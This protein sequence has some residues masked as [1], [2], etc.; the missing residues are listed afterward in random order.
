MSEKIVPT[1]VANFK[2]LQEGSM[3]LG[4]GVGERRLGLAPDVQIL[5]R[6][7]WRR[8]AVG[9]QRLGS[10]VAQPG[11]TCGYVVQKVEHDLL[12]IAHQGPELDLATVA[13]RQQ[14]FQ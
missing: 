2:L 14:N 9:P 3:A 7:W 4:Q 6:C 11:G 12:V 8:Y 10:T 1:L 13:R 5:R